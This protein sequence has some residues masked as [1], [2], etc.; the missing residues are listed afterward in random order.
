MEK[1]VDEALRLWRAGRSVLPMRCDG[2]KCS[3]L[4]RWQQYIE[5]RATEDEVRKWFSGEEKVGIAAL[6]GMVSGGTVCFDFERK[7]VYQEWEQRVNEAIPGFLE[8]GCLVETPRGYHFHMLIECDVKGRKLAKVPAT[9]EKW[10]EETKKKEIIKTGTAIIETRGHGNYAILPGSPPECHPQE[11]TYHYRVG[12]LTE[13]DPFDRDDYELMIQIAL[14]F[15]EWKDPD[16][17]PRG[18]IKD[19]DADDGRVGTD[20]CH[21]GDFEALLAKHDWTMLREH[22]ARQV[23]KRPGKIDRG[24][25]ATLGFVNTD[26]GRELFVFSTNAE[27]FEENRCYSLFGA[28]TLLEHKGNWGAAVKALA[29]Q[30]Y[31]KRAHADIERLV[32]T[33]IERVRRNVLDHSLAFDD[34]E[35]MK[36]IITDPDFRRR[37]GRKINHHGIPGQVF[38]YELSLI[39]MGMIRWRLPDRRYY[40]TVAL[41]YEFRKKW[42]EDPAVVLDVEKMA[43]L[44]EWADQNR[45]TPEETML[46]T[47]DLAS[48][49]GKDAYLQMIRKQIGMEFLAGFRINGGD[50]AA[51]CFLVFIDGHELCLGKWSEWNRVD[52]FFERIYT[53]PHLQELGYVAPPY[54]IY[55]ISNWRQVLAGFSMIKQVTNR[56]ITAGYENR[57]HVV[58]Y[59]EEHPASTDQGDDNAFIEAFVARQPLEVNGSTL[60][61]LFDFRP[62]AKANQNYEMSYAALLSFFESNGFSVQTIR[63]RTPVGRRERNYMT[64]ETSKL[65]RFEGRIAE[66]DETR[67]FE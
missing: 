49:K 36:S 67:H 42:G 55:K 48:N 15:N 10:N 29:E 5:K 65:N 25:S 16:R 35:E 17:I 50:H 61:N 39:R 22:E 60:I 18:E 32:A 33:A 58:A 38:T 26:L 54:D 37:W 27:P 62:W 4:H 52:A 28:Y 64:I 3:T 45:E 12:D 13:L 31:G 66:K 46:A 19:V 11:K 57:R 1:L 23:W 40:L 43:K 41:R 34:P 14:S 51:P 47:Y 7:N 44:V 59:L 6:Q 21:R 9:R 56:H 20:F 63:H 2:S 24:G 30:G 8:R 53:D